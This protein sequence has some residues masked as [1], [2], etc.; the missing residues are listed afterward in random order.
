MNREYA[1]DL[2]AQL[3]TAGAE[4]CGGAADSRAIRPGNVFFAWPGA[5]GD[6]RKHV[7]DA[8]ANGAVAV[9]WERGDDLAPVECGVPVIE[10][11]NL[12]ARAGWIAHELYDKPSEDLWVVGITGTNGKTT[13]SRWVAQALG[14]LDVPCGVIGTL[15]KGFPDQLETLGNTTPD[16]VLLHRTLKELAERGAAGVAVEVSS[17]S[18]DHERVAGVDFDVA[19]FTNLSRDHLE[20][21][22][23]MEAYSEAKERLFDWPRLDCAVINIDDAFGA[24]LAARLTARGQRLIACS[25]RADTYGDAPV[26]R[27]KPLGVVPSGI[28]FTVCENADEAEV[29]LAAVG[30]FNVANALAVI[31]VLRARG[32]KL[33]EAAYAVSK[34]SPP[35]GRMQLVG[36]VGEP[37]VIIDYAHTPDALTKVLEAA[38][39]AARERGGRL[40]CVF[41]CG[42]ERDPGKRPLMG[43]VAGR[44]ADRTIVTNDNPRSEAP[45]DIADMVLAEA[46]AAAECELDR[47]AAIHQAVTDSGLDDVIVIAGKG[48]EL[49]QEINGTHLPFSDAEQAARALAQRKQRGVP[50][51]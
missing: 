27:A 44:L 8:V 7:A 41:G 42:G 45:Q 1:I 10:V 15:G 16:A 12:R 50:T 19:V 37:L 21:H 4:V 2:I 48:H 38:R 9:L 39:G 40:V 3:R 26:L 43:E 51:T 13:T 6:G 11:Q 31:G 22:R 14:A 49:Y 33:E 47:A 30:E 34:V 29:A 25:Q 36:G 46:G 5:K 20:Y 17:I 32:V 23:T 24:A 35:P 28:R 18:L